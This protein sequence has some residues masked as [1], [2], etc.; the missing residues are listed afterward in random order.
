[1]NADVVAHLEHVKRI[2]EQN[3]RLM[4]QAQQACKDAF[5]KGAS[6]LFDMYPCLK[7]FEWAQYTPYFNDGET[8]YFRSGHTYA[9]IE[10]HDEIEG[11]QKEATKAVQEF[12][13]NFDDDDMLA[14]FD[15]HAQVT[16]T[17]DGAVSEEYEH[18]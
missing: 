2:K 10:F 4:E 15:D 7:S 11:D 16:V 8:C 17:I 18:D 9:D 12:L 6:F 14:M 13:N 3:N 1:M 5:G